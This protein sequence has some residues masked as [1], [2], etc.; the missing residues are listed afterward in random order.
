RSCP[1]SG[2]PSSLLLLRYNTAGT[3]GTLD[4]SFG[5]GGI[6]TTA[7][8]S[9]SAT[10]ANAIA[11]SGTNILLAG[12]SR[13][14]GKLTITVAQYTSSGALDPAFGTGGIVTTPIASL[15]A[16]AGALAVQGDGKIVVAGL[17]GTAFTNFWDVA[18]LRYNA[19]GSLDTAFG[20][21]D[22]IVTTDI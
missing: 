6:V 4:T 10:A 11:L 8:P 18:L 13:I 3:P 7:V 17:A 5:T 21:G 16:D 14:S 1:L 2:A 19:D 20:G 22:G 9:G 15:D 12:H